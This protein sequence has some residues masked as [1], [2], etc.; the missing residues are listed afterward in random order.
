[1]SARASLCDTTRTMTGR[2]ARTLLALAPTLAACAED[3]DPL[4][5]ATQPAP[6]TSPAASASA[7]PT[8]DTTGSTDTGTTGAP[9]GPS[10][11]DAVQPIWDEYCLAA[12]HEPAGSG[13]SVLLLTP[14]DAYLQLVGVASPAYPDLVRVVPGDREA[15][16]LWHKLGGT[17][18]EFGGG[19]VKMPI[20][21]ALDP[22]ELEVVGAWID[23]GAQP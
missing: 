20:Y 1:M 18:L 6:A 13:A 9:A 15:S 17:H 8:G 23:Q 11:A 19:G 12:C 14:N 16:Y 22:D 7:D 2:L 5:S 4:A 3:L 21:G 10:H